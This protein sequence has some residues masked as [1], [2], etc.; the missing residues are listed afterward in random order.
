MLRLAFLALVAACGAAPAS[1]PIANNAGSGDSRPGEIGGVVT[2]AKTGE[3][4]AG[5]TVIVQ[6]RGESPPPNSEIISDAQGRWRRRELEAGTYVVN[7][8]YADFQVELVDV[9]V[10]HGKT[11]NADYKLDQSSEA[12]G[13]V[14]KVP[15]R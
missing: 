6:R 5:A 12:A 2:D 10:E 11:T 13:E 15:F 7:I 8:Y 9:P 1:R 14:K 4:I 3:P